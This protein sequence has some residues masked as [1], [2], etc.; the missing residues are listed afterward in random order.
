MKKLLRYGLG[1][2]YTPIIEI[3][4]FIVIIVFIL[5][6][7]IISMIDGLLSFFRLK[8]LYS[9]FMTPFMGSIHHTIKLLFF[10]TKKK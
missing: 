1:I 5:F 3:L 4:S 9:E 8:K 7:I 10:P 6:T 2:I